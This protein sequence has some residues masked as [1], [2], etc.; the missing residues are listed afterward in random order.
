MYVIG[1]WLGDSNKASDEVY[2]LNLDSYHWKAIT[3]QP[4]IGSSNMHTADLYKNEIYIFR[5]GNGTE[6]MND[7]IKLNVDDKQVTFLKTAGKIPHVRANH[8]SA[9][10][11]STLFI[12]GGWSGSKRLND[13]HMINLESLIWSEIEVYVNVPSARAGASLISHQDYLI[14]FGGSGPGVYLNDLHF[15]DTSNYLSIHITFIYC[16]K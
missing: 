6:Y 16:S 2:E 14:L 13:L 5:G 12:F 7:L 10:V 11:K 4:S 15:F 1:G 9:L 8:C 3:T